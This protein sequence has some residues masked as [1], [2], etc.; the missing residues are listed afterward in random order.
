MKRQRGLAFAFAAV[1][2]AS[3]CA[4]ELP[5]E[6]HVVLYID[7]DAPLPSAPGVVR[8]PSAPPPL[9]D[10][11]RVDIIRAGERGPCEGC[12]RDL[13]LDE[14][15]VRRGA[16]MTI[17]PGDVGSAPPTVRLRMYRS[18]GVIG[19]PDP[20]VE[21]YVSLPAFPSEGAAEV[22]AFLPT[23]ALGVPIGSLDAPEAPTLGFSGEG[24]AG[25]WP[26]ATR[27]PCSGAPHAGEVCVPGGA[28]WMGDRLAIGADFDVSR[29]G[30]RL[31]VVAPFWLD[32]E[33]VTV[34]EYRDGKGVGALE[35]SGDYDGPFASNLQDYCTFTKQVDDAHDPLPVNCVPPGGAE[36][37]CRRKGATLPTEAQHEYARGSLR[38]APFPWGYDEPSCEDTVFGK[39]PSVPEDP[40]VAGD[41]HEEGA[42]PLPEALVLDDGG[43]RPG[44]DA[45]VLSEGTVWD[46]AGNLSEWAADM[47]QEVSEPCWP[48]SGSR[49][50]VDPVCREASAASPYHAIRGGNFLMSAH[51]TRAAS[52]WSGFSSPL[53]GF[54]CARPDAGAP[55]EPGCAGFLEGGLDACDRCA[56]QRCCGAI[57]EDGGLFGVAASRCAFDACSRACGAVLFAPDCRAGAALPAEGPCV[58]IEGTVQCNPVTNEGCP[59]PSFACDADEDGFSCFPPPNEA[60]LCAAC[61]PSAGPFCAP[62]STCM[63]GPDAGCVKYCCSDDDCAGG[64][65]WKGGDAPYFPEAPS[66][67]LCAA[68]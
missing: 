56:E 28:F 51:W 27:V 58:A 6:G 20:A 18:Q 30:E 64:R 50:A 42:P 45:L 11:V 16:S 21:L 34:E 52:R 14:E 63:F 48:V 24:H 38:S 35:W 33:E 53:I 26:G 60:A 57:L 62:G 13:D 7:T 3:A 40:E 68:L 5:P 29:R 15:T 32:S 23:D 37:Y 43:F 67:G 8:D 47:F 46:L 19:E 17:V 2:C 10:R 31:V 66:L 39:L 65:C 1:A 9:F 44:R 36:A 25:T 12:S 4:D 49:L 22:T 59:D 41:C 54:R 61:D 55:P